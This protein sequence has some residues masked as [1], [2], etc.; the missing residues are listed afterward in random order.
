[1]PITYT[2]ADDSFLNTY[3][4]YSMQWDLHMCLIDSQNTCYV[5][6]PT[7][8]D[9]IHDLFKSLTNNKANAKVNTTA[10]AK[11]NAKPKPKPKPNT[12]SKTKTLEKN[13]KVIEEVKEVHDVEYDVKYN[14]Y[15]GLSIKELRTISEYYGLCVKLQSKAFIIKSILL[16]EQCPSNAA[17][18]SERVKL[19][20]YVVYLRTHPFM[21]NH[22][23]F[24][25]LDYSLL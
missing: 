21:K 23:T 7:H 2:I 19:W 16:F 18:V 22:L 11:A 5:K 1:M 25:W 24:T 12:R 14:Y 10:K 9:V 3:Y 4:N 17:C 8:A 20:E 15:N 6:P 13:T